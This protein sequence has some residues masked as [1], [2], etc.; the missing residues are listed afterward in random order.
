MSHELM[1]ETGRRYVP[2]NKD[3]IE[4]NVIKDSEK[5]Q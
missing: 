1:Q 5:E 2:Q 3:N 4:K